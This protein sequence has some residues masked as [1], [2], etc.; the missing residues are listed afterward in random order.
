VDRELVKLLLQ[1]FELVGQILE[2]KR[3]SHLPIRDAQRE[4]EILEKLSRAVASAPC[5]EELVSIF[6]GILKVSCEY[7]QKKDRVDKA[8]SGD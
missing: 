5:M 3:N 6:Q 2:E 4:K 7:M 1:R 8:G